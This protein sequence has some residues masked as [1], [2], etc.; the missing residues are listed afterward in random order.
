[1]NIVVVG[2]GM[3]GH[4]YVETLVNAKQ[5]GD[6]D[7]NIIIVGGETRPAYDRVHLSEVFDG[8]Q[9]DDLA[10]CTREQYKEWGVNAHFG[11]FVTRIDRDNKN[12]RLVVVCE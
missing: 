2:N 6:I 12:V 8:K 1:M 10:M 4:H 7:A 3:V 9:P 11:D 5:R